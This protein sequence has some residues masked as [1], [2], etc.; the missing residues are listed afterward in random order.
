[1]DAG[2][3]AEKL[4]K[5][6]RQ[7]AHQGV[8]V[9][10]SGGVDSALLLKLAYMA[11]REAGGQAYAVTVHTRLHPAGEMEAAEKLCMEIDRKSVV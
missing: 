2:M 6:I 4:R 5:M 10:F 9:A 8:M 1:M 7:Y 3:K 11:A